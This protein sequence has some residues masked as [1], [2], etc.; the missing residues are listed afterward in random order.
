MAEEEDAEKQAIE[1]VMGFS[2][3]GKCTAVVTFHAGGLL[4]GKKSAMQFDVDK[5]FAE[6]RRSAQEYTQRVAS[7]SVSYKTTQFSCS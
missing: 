2:G 7:Q 5:V 4:V 3:F 1:S 6:T